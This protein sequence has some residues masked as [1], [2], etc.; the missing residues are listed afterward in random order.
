MSQV[1]GGASKLEAMVSCPKQSALLHD[2]KNSL[3]SAEL[4]LHVLFESLENP[5]DHSREKPLSS[6]WEELRGGLF[7]SMRSARHLVKELSCLSEGLGDTPV[8]CSATSKEDLPASLREICDSVLWEH[9]E[10]LRLSPHPVEARIELPTKV[11]WKDHQLSRAAG[12][13]LVK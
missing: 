8:I 7:H 12:V 2:L 4:C 6:R 13:W 9:S 3:S 1:S 11:Q 5:E 10:R